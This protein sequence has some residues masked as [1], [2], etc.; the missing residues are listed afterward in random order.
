M[1]ILRLT[2]PVNFPA[3]SGFIS[4]YH[5]IYHEKGEET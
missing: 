1:N 4:R 2:E 5:D 3:I